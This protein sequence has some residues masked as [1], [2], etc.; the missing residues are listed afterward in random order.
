M[1]AMHTK[2]AVAEGGE[3]LVLVSYLETVAGNAE[4]AHALAQSAHS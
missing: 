1:L 3:E 2:R 4:D